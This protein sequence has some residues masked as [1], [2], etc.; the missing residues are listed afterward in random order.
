MV[1]AN[2]HRWPRFGLRTLLLM[3]ILCC[4]MLTARHLYLAPF[5]HTVRVIDQLRR[6][7]CYAQTQP[8]NGPFFLAWLVGK[9]DF[10]VLI[11]AIAKSTIESLRSAPGCTP[12]AISL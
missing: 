8:A 5:R 9:E 7:D 10:V 4:L 6:L 1:Q 3:V 2:T 11:C 12:C